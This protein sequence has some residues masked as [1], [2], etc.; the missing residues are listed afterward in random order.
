MGSNITKVLE[1]RRGLETPT[2]TDPIRKN[3][4]WLRFVNSNTNLSHAHSRI[5]LAC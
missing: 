5:L 1:Q 4:G 2:P 3:L